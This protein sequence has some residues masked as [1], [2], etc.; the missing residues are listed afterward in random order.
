[1][2]VKFN[3]MYRDGTIQTWL[4]SGI[5][6]VFSGDLGTR[7]IYPWSRCS[8][9]DSYNFSIRCGTQRVI[10]FYTF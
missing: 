5:T 10:R 2:Q 6:T 8:C 7:I 1:M 3:C 4:I 9:S